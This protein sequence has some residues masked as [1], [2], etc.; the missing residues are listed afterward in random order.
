MDPLQNFEV[1]GKKDKLGTLRCPREGC[2]GEFTVDREKFKEKR[3]TAMRL[4]PYCCRVSIV[5]GKNIPAYFDREMVPH[6]F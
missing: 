3:A 6:P 2:G 1:V 4:C 5:P